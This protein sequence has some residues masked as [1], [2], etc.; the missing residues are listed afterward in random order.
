MSSETRY[1]VNCKSKSIAFRGDKTYDQ[2]MAGGKELDNHE[3]RFSVIEF[4]SMSELDQ[5]TDFS[6]YEIDNSYKKIINN[7]C[8][9]GKIKK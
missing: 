1:V 2:H 9:N 3:R 5:I 8:K 7:A 4:S 6:I